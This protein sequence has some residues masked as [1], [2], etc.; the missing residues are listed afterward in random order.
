[1]VPKVPSYLRTYRKRGGLTQ[2][3]VAFLLGCQSGT[4][5]SRYERLCRQPNLQT[6]FACQAIFGIPAHEIFPGMYAEVE[7]SI[8]KRARQLSKRIEAQDLGGVANQKLALLRAI[9]SQGGGEHAEP[10]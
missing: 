5:L 3:E 7:Q 6:A 8:A 1:M 10:S 4:K 9:A 2:N